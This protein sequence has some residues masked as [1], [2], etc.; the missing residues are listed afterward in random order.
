ME[1]K[2]LTIMIMLGGLFG[3]L[4]FYFAIDAITST[5]TPIADNYT[6][7]NSTFG[8]VLNSTQKNVE[9]MQSIGQGGGFSISQSG[10]V[11]LSGLYN[12]VTLPFA[13]ALSIPTFITEINK[14]MGV[15]TVVT[16]IFLSLILITLVFGTI[17]LIFRKDF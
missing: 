14:I 2:E 4:I 9:D 15:P 8:R 3:V 1:V 7:L 12:I 13:L 10:F 11:L 5:N 17:A 6:I 16:G